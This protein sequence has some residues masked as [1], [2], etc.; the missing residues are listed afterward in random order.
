MRAPDGFRS[1]LINEVFL[2]WRALMRS[3]IPRRLRTAVVVTGLALVSLLAAP[4]AQ[5]API[6]DPAQAADLAAQLGDTRTAGV[7]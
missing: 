7:Y 5:A 3:R 4:V 6:S 1:Q 2:S